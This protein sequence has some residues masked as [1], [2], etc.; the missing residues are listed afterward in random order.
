MEISGCRRRPVRLALGALA[1][2]LA[3]GASQLR[4]AAFWPLMTATL[5]GSGLSVG[6]SEERR[7]GLPSGRW[8]WQGAACGIGMYA[9]T[10]GAARILSRTG[11]GRLS[12]D[13]LER[14]TGSVPPTLA[15]LLALPAACG[16]EWFW[17]EGVLGAELARGGGPGPA[18]LRSTL[19][20][21]A[22]Q[23]AAVDPLP[24]AGAILLGGVTGA[25]RL[26]SDSIWPGLIAH[27]VYSE[28]TLVAPGLP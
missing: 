19:W 18:L 25:L 14:C 7:V 4:P 16:E 10:F 20:Y 26:T 13:Q 21:A 3:L 6:R 2:S 22:V 28:L 8:L 1:Q 12:L 24:P 9:L 5:V 15:A 17:R 11:P 23:M 27:V